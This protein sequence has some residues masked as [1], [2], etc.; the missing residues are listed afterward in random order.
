MLSQS[1]ALRQCARED[2]A[3]ALAHPPR[4]LRRPDGGC[5][6]HANFSSPSVLLPPSPSNDIAERVE[7]L[8]ALGQ[9]VVSTRASAERLAAPLVATRG[10][11]DRATSGIVVSEE[12]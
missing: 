1:P 12:L 3:E 2:S 10:E 9:L 6:V 5:A 8:V 4:R 7:V 11:I